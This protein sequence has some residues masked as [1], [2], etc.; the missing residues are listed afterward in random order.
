MPT[1]TYK[2]KDCGKRFE[3]VM[4]LQEHERQRKAPCPKCQS[5]NVQQLPSQFQTVTSTKA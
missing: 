1:Y 3:K 2:C 4:A 5:K